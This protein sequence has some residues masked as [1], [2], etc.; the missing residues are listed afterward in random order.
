MLMSNERTVH[1]QE[2]DNLYRAGQFLADIL[3][4]LMSGLSASG[5]IKLLYEK[6][7]L[8][9]DNALLMQAIT[10]A[11]LIV[12]APDISMVDG[13]E[14][15]LTEAERSEKTFEKEAAESARDL[16][17]RVLNDPELAPHSVTRKKTD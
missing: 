2:E 11:G 1:Y 15:I 8:Q 7:L 13:A 9:R 3:L 16:I 17:T 10:V 12:F 14:S 6:T 4:A 5:N